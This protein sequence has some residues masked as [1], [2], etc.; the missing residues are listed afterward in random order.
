MIVLFFEPSARPS[1]VRTV[2]TR[3]AP[4]ARTP[5]EKRNIVGRQ[6][7]EHMNNN[8]VQ[9]L[10]RLTALAL[11]LL[12]G[13]GPVFAGIQVS[14]ADGIQATGADG[15]QYI[16]TSG[17]QA[18]GA[19]GYLSYGVNGIQA[20]GADGISNSVPNGIQA[21]GADGSTYVGPNGIQATGADGIQAT[22]ADGIQATGADGIQIS[23]ADGTS[24]HVDSV[25]I[26][27]AS[28]IQATGADTVN[29]VGADGIQATGADGIQATGADGMTLLRANGIQISGADGIQATGADGQTFSISPDGIQISGA[30]EMIIS[31]PTGI[32]ISSASSIV[33]TGTET[34]AGAGI[35]PAHQLGLQS[36]DPELALQLD[37][38]TDDSNVNAVVTFHHQV[39]N[40]DL[41]DLRSLN[42]TNGTLYRVLPMVAVTATKRQLLRVSH[43]PSVRS[44]YGNRTLQST[45]DTRLDING[46]NRAGLD[47]DLSNNNGGT[48]L[49]G[50]GVTVAVLDT[51]LDGTHADLSGRVVQNV[52][53]LD[54]QSVNVG[55]NNPLATENLP[56][57]DQAYGHGTFVA[58]VIAGNGT[59]SDG[60]YSGVAPN[61]RLVGL[62]AGDLT[63]SFV[64]SG[65]DYLLANNEKLN[66]RVLNCS[67]SAN[68]L[69]DVND[70]VNIATRIL[71]E[72]GVNVVFS[73][74]NTG[75]GLHTLNP[76]AVAPWVI[77]V[78]ATD[79]Q[80]H[81]ASFSS[82][83]DF[84]SA[85]FHPTLVAPGVG[86]ISLRAS[87]VNLTGTNGLAGGDASLAPTELPFY[88]TASG[89]S[90]SAPQ[91]AGTVALM[92][93]ANPNLTP[94]QVRDILCRTATPLP[95]YYQHEAGAGMLN[96]YA[97]MLEA[98]FPQRR[99]GAWRATLDRG[100]VRFV[101]DPAQIFNGTVR[102][103]Y[104]FQSPS[105][106]I[107][108]N[109]VLA[110]FQV[111]WGPPTT[112]NDMTLSVFDPRGVKQDGGNTVNQPGLT[113]KRERV[114][115]RTPAAGTWSARVT[116]SLGSLGLLNSSQQIYG[117]LEVTRIEY[118]PLSDVSGLSA[119]S[120]AEIYQSLQMFTMF[121]F[122]GRYHPGFGVSRA[123]L[124]AALVMSGRVP[125]YMPSQS[126][127][128]DVTDTTT[129]NFV[130]SVQSAAG[131]RLFADAAPGGYFRPYEQIDRATAAVTLVRAAGLQNEIFTNDGS[132][133]TKLTDADAIP[134]TKR[135]YVAVA[136]SHNLLTVENFNF[137]P[138]S[139]LTRAELAHALATLVGN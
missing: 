4:A 79:N 95:N 102:S 105:L 88:T 124:A 22:G 77:S 36:V 15:I 136:L 131:G 5:H 120:R 32:L 94:A 11:I 53:L 31:L 19:D 3:G 23:G 63:L 101:T 37:R 132:A 110:S 117:A 18:T 43:L 135:A 65:F 41:A 89:T 121:P 99:I 139:I 57:T 34:L 69:Y 12:L 35:D 26:R 46:V 55:F 61:A 49:T 78:G 75:S 71:T 82:R 97:A 74:G 68:A 109:A 118:A 13:V 47:S 91:V 16:N 59:R 50:R 58:G 42:V 116:N 126:H 7:P 40:A 80:G 114:T 98:A 129:M 54:T 25:L 48:P 21:T 30:D 83:G 133:L 76:Y 70:P 28:G 51:G 72:R 108:Q 73:A 123:Q 60:K 87:G 44:V 92:L 20:T 1:H 103:G 93:E 67:F 106:T 66:A 138:Q 9:K 122:S 39:S 107:P 29:V 62:S 8:M 52:K 81:L 33:R 56:N 96:A 134:E 128:L 2:P 27:R 113:G 111:A 14:G 112:S 85:L 64:L 104:E 130:E 17:I 84:G 45:M 100:Q 38:L 24:Y 125:Q 119:P 115:V 6:L 10:Y 137:R 127:Y 90:F 86:I